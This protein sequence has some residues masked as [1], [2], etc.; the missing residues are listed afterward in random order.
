MSDKKQ[1]IFDRFARL[2]T[3]VVGLQYYEDAGKI[4]NADVLFERDPKNPFDKNA[5]AVFTT[6]GVKIGHLPQ[7]DAI[8][9]SP[10]ILQGVVALKGRVGEGNRGDIAPLALEVFATSKV[11]EITV[12]DTSDD[13]RAVYHNIFVDIWERLSEYSALTLHE[14]RERFRPLAHEQPLFP[15]TQ[16]LYRMLKAHIADL[17]LQ[18]V[19]RFRDQIVA[20]IKEMS[21]GAFMGWPE[22]TVI[23]LDAS[24]NPLPE[25]GSADAEVSALAAMDKEIDVLRLLPSKCPYPVGAHGAIVMVR[26]DF[27]SLDWFD[28]VECAEVYWYQM[29]LSG[30]KN[31]MHNDLYALPATDIT[32]D[33]IKKD[34]LELM[35]H[36]DC[37]LTDSEERNSTRVGVTAGDHVG[38]AIYSDSK[39]VRLNLCDGENGEIPLAYDYTNIE[40]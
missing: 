39:L 27:Y 23:P 7:Y 28:S 37:E 36:A 31:A 11:S 17:K 9:L 4:E 10:L 38:Y 2:G 22:L 32:S 33:N 24:G 20:S 3:W 15:K 21:F 12:R 5:V 29:I 25:L 26:S 14:F 40:D 8:Y 34:I 6:N 30:M 18:E 1:D 16:F 35:K 19:I 13:W